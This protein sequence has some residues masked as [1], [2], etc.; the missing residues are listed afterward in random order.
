[1]SF[2]EALLAIIKS[3]PEILKF[4]N[5]LGETIGS[6]S[7]SIKEQNLNAWLD[8][9]NQATQELK[10]AKTLRDRITAAERLNKLS[11]GM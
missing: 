7:E 8:E 1:M 5:K 4:I 10:N 11:R 9:L 2:G 3:L 6:I